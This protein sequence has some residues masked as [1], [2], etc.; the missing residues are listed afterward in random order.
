M[1]Q[2][3]TTA[4]RVRAVQI[5]TA[6]ALALL[7]GCGAIV[8]CPALAQATN[9]TLTPALAQGFLSRSS[10]LALKVSNYDNALDRTTQIA[11]DNGAQL[12][13]SK[14]YVDAK[15]HKHG[16]IRLRVAATAFDALR[17]SLKKIGV[18]YSDAVGANDETSDFETLGRRAG[19]LSVHQQR[20]EGILNSKRRLR[21]SDILY[22]QDRL[23]S[24]GTDQQ[25]LLQERD[26]IQR[27]TQTSMLMVELFEPYTLPPPIH[28]APIPPTIRFHTSFNSAHRDF[29]SLLD[30][31][32]TAVAYAVTYAPIWGPA[33]AITIL[34]LVMLWRKRGAIGAFFVR[35]VGAAIDAKHRIAPQIEQSRS[36]NG[37]NS[38]HGIEQ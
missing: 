2:A 37:P 29:S 38:G 3:K 26:D 17:S 14:T 5:A 27:G 30:R 6:A 22:I 32:A 18:L 36:R 8:K 35:C 7:L 20:L 19:Q 15:G 10:T 9:A 12:M 34:I 1:I 13:D 33:L 25:D 28:A 11:T 16:W 24:A 23:F 4:V 21:G 31:S